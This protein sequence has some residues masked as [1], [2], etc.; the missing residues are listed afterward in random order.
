VTWIGHIKGVA[1]SRM[2]LRVEGE[3]MTEEIALPGTLQ[4]GQGVSPNHDF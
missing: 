4:G 2:I 1:D 3:A